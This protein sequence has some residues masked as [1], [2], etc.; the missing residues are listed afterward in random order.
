M[1][2]YDYFRSSASYRVR[3]ALNIK[4]L[5]YEKHSVHLLNNGGEQHHPEYSR[6]N[7][8]ELVPTLITDEAQA[9][10]QSLAI[11]EYLN[12]CYP[13]P[14]LLPAAPFHRAEVRSMALLIACD[15]HPLNNLRVLN[16]LRQQ[17]QASDEQVT[18]WMH[19]WM[20]TGFAAFE[21]KLVDL[22][23]KGKCCFGEQLTLAD[24]CLIPQVFNAKRFQVNMEEYPL[25]NSVYDECT[26]LEVFKQAAPAE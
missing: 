19:H 18:S 9:I 1:I 8:Q 17:F 11:I 24:I 6:L 7:P 20:Q 25:I 12:D 13:T 23:C 22:A 14:P 10:S 5:N 16:Q 3:I 26:S 4:G 15:M 2:L 21:Q